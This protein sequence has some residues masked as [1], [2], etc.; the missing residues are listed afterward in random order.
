MGSCPALVTKVR[1]ANFAVKALDATCL[2]S[3]KG[4]VPTQDERDMQTAHTSPGRRRTSP[5]T[6]A[7]QL[8]PPPS[9]K[10]TPAQVGAV[11]K[12]ARKLGRQDVL[13]PYDHR[14][15]DALLFQCRSPNTGAVVVS[16]SALQRITGMARATVAKGIARLTSCGLLTKIKRRLRVSWHQGGSASLQAT[17]AYCFNPPT[18]DTEFAPQTV[19]QKLEFSFSCQSVSA[20]VQ[21]AR[22]DLAQI[23]IRRAA[24]QETQRAARV[25]AARQAGQFVAS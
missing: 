15:L 4:S 24:Q 8:P 22:E 11:M 16:Y 21:Q 9:Q 19:D 23:R 12:R 18:A 14:L 13:T 2:P 20:E 25:L 7:I 6:K 5:V 17:S 10:L 1:S 3:P